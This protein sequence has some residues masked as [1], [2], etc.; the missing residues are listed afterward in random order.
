MSFSL[1]LTRFKFKQNF[2]VILTFINLLKSAIN[3]IVVV[4]FDMFIW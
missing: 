4:C 2:E 1:S 3:S